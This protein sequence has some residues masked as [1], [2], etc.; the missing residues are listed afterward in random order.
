MS[1]GFS[2]FPALTFLKKVSS[3]FLNSE[4][5]QRLFKKIKAGNSRKAIDRLL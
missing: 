2:E 1:V 5:G 4:R 3:P